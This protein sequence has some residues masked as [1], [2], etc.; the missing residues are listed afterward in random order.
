[1]SRSIASRTDVFFSVAES[2]YYD[3]EEEVSVNIEEIES[4]EVP[5]SESVIHHYIVPLVLA[6]RNSCNYH[7]ESQ[8]RAQC[9]GCNLL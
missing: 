5:H 7:I 6:D 1:M 3:A 9:R 8:S 4:N 2:V